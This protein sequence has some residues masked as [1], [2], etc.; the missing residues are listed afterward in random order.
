M[1]VQATMTI[2]VIVMSWRHF[3]L[4]FMLI[5]AFVA[6]IIKYRERTWALKLAC[7]DKS[8]NIVPFF[9]DVIDSLVCPI[10]VERDEKVE[11][12]LHAGEGI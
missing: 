10:K 4:S 2:Y 5:L 7:H 8:G 12:G 6:G 9:Y 11:Y 1:G 3:W